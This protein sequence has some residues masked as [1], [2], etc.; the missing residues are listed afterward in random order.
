MEPLRVPV[1]PDPSIDGALVFRATGVL[2][3]DGTRRASVD[4]ALAV[5]LDRPG[6][7]RDLEAAMAWAVF[8]GGRR[9]RPLL[10]LAVADMCGSTADHALPSAAAVELLHN[11][12][13]VYDD[14]PCMDDSDERRGRPTVHVRFGEAV[15]I[16]AGVGLTT[17]AFD[18]LARSRRGGRAVRLGARYIGPNQILTGQAIDLREPLSTGPA[19]ANRKNKKTSALL[20]LS[21]LL[22]AN[23]GTTTSV[24]RKAL[25]RF[26]RG[27][28]RAYQLFDDA[29]DC[30]AD[31]RHAPSPSTLV[32][33]GQRELAM[34]RAELVVA[35]PEGARRDRVLGFVD[36]LGRIPT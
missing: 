13:L 20:V 17:L 24:Q 7:D 30:H 34:A 18:L 35:F 26:G 31:R 27:L 19:A 6:T 16:L 23:Q 29:I 28:G 9:W 4:D 1:R 21:A 10:T 15:A 32:Q 36:L 25:F 22:G 11:S 14:L 3:P 5:A 2:D 33:L 12:S 8:P